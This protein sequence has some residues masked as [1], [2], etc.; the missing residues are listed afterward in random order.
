MGD[1]NARTPDKYNLRDAQ[2]ARLTDGLPIGK[3][4]E[5]PMKASH[6][7]PKSNDKSQTVN[8]NLE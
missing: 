5:S 1:P 8:L 6:I 2:I 7:I 4:V 3:L